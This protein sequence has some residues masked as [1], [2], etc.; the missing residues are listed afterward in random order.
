MSTGTAGVVFGNVSIGIVSLVFDILGSFFFLI[1]VVIA[2]VV[3]VTLAIVLFPVIARAVGVA[4]VILGFILVPVNVGIAGIAFV[5]GGIGGIVSIIVAIAGVACAV[6]KTIFLLLSV[7][8]PSSIVS[9]V[10]LRF[11][12]AVVVILADLPCLA[13]GFCD[14][15]VIQTVTRRLVV[16]GDALDVHGGRSLGK[17]LSVEHCFEIERRLR[18][19][20][21]GLIRVVKEAFPQRGI[22]CNI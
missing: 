4:F 11:F 14:Y 9:I 7:P 19:V 13:D 22:L 15:D 3:F 20:I 10:R 8:L 16:L 21:D 18:I 1:I 6:A 2:S 12:I 17:Q 5:I